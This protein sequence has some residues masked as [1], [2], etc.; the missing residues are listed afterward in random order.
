M[1]RRGFSVALCDQLEAT[2]AKGAL[3][4]TSP[5]CSPPAVLGLLSAR[6]NNWLAA[7]VVE[8]AQG[9]RPLCWGLASADRAPARCR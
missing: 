8:P 3:L 7:V 2:P 9:D 5:G 6:R 4:A 1:I